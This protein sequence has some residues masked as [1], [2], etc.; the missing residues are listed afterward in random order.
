MQEEWLEGVRQTARQIY[1]SNNYIC[2]KHSE[3]SSTGQMGGG[4]KQQTNQP[5]GD[6]GVGGEGV[7]HAVFWP[8]ITRA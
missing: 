4:G 7:F 6:G 3:I 8:I 1:S 5:T 2:G